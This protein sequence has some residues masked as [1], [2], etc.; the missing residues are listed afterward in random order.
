MSSGFRELY[1]ENSGRVVPHGT[2]VC[3]VLA[4]GEY[5]WLRYRRVFTL[6]R[7]MMS[8]NGIARVAV[9]YLLSPII[10]IWWVVCSAVLAFLF[11]VW[12]CM[13]SFGQCTAFFE[14]TSDSIVRKVD[15][16]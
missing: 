5:V 9:S 1:R 14:W 4:L 12:M 6:H 10:W 15:D 3:F 13:Y 7:K 16:D 11:V 2:V 8:N